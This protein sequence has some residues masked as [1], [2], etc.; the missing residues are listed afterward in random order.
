MEIANVKGE[1]KFL[2]KIAK[3]DDEVFMQKTIAGERK[4][5]KQNLSGSVAQEFWCV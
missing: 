2:R 4:M 5:V 1:R 3:C